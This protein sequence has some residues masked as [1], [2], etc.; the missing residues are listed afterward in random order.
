MEYSVQAVTF[1]TDGVESTGVKIL[2]ADTVFVDVQSFKC[3]G[4]TVGWNP[5]VSYDGS[6]YRDFWCLTRASGLAGISNQKLLVNQS[7]GNYTARIP[8]NGFSYMRLVTNLTATASYSVN[9][10]VS[11]ANV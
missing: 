11:V 9:V 8:V 1:S 5:Q 4:D 6:T 10:H 3:S 2:G 7:T